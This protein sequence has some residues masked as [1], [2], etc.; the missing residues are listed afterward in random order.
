VNDILSTREKT[1]I[2]AI[3]KSITPSLVKV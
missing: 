3:V 1:L 2:V